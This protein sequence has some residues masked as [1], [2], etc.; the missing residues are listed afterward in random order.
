[1]A[2]QPKEEAF[3][4]VEAALAFIGKR[5]G[6]IEKTGQNTHFRYRFV[7]HAE[8]V[9]RSAP[10]LHTAGIIVNP[11]VRTVETRD[12]EKGVAVTVIMAVQFR[13]SPTDMVEAVVAGEGMDT[14]D[15]AVS[16]A[17]T[18]ALKRA[19]M[20]VLGLAVNEGLDDR[21]DFNRSAR[22]P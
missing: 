4:T 8:V 5:I 19:Y 10:L 13:R 7:E 16:K 1:M 14:Q 12:L 15:K 3:P 21:A 9:A 18:Q 22:R 11:V 20:T 6:T 2:D 17:I